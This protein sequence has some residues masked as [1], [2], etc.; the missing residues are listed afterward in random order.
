MHVDGKEF[1]SN[2]SICLTSLPPNLNRTLLLALLA[3]TGNIKPYSNVNVL[4]TVGQFKLFWTCYSFLPI[5]F[6]PFTFYCLWIIFS[7]HICPTSVIWRIGPE[8]YLSC[9]L[10]NS[11]MLTSILHIVD[12]CKIFKNKEINGIKTIGH[13]FF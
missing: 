6:Y 3:Q 1:K 7:M 2:S 11:P 13:S 8:S 9:I 10:S 12:F 5:S 4:G